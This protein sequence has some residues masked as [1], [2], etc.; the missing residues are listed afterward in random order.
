MNYGQ[1]VGG[2]DAALAYQKGIA[3]MQRE[4]EQQTVRDCTIGIRDAQCSG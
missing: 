4:L 1:A 2:D 3:I